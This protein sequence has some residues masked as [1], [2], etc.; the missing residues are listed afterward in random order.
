MSKQLAMNYGPMEATP[1][2]VE[3][4]EHLISLCKTYRDAVKLC[5]NHSIVPYT[6]GQWAEYMGM[7]EGSLS[8]ILNY[9]EK[10]R[11]RNLDPDLFD[12]I[13]RKAGNSAID[14]FFTLQRKGG[15][16]SQQTTANRKQELLAE[17]AELEN[18]EAV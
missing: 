12:L 15:L 5:M 17:L 10:G 14:Q 16:R 18:R 1:L 7:N 2:P 13:Q 9:R 3:L 11:K 4:P 8:L 6:Q